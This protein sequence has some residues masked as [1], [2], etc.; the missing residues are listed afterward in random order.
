[1]PLGQFGQVFLTPV[2]E[3]DHRKE[4]DKEASQAHHQT[5]GPE[6]HRDIRHQFCLVLDIAITKVLEVILDDLRLHS[7][8]CLIACS[9]SL[10]VFCQGNDGLLTHLDLL[11]GRRFLCTIRTCITI[12]D[13]VHT[14]HISVRITSSHDRQRIRHSDA[15]RRFFIH[16][17]IRLL[18]GVHPCHTRQTLVHTTIIE[19]LHGSQ[20][21]R[22]FL[23]HLFSGDMSGGR[24]QERGHKT[25]D[26]SDTHALQGH[27]RL[28]LLHQIPAAYSHHEDCSDN[29]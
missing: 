10:P 28:T 29:P 4:Q 27:L 9:L 2:H 18:E 19:C 15:Q 21:H 7:C 1:M 6:V 12:Q 11:I 13:V 14:R 26:G 22:L 8:R 24:S 23:S 5:E 25:Y 3:E 20:L 16:R 17:I